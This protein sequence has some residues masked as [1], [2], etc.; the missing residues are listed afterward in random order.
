MDPNSQS[1]ICVLSVESFTALNKIYNIDSSSNTLEVG[2]YSSGGVLTKTVITV[3]SGAYDIYT[4]VDALNESFND[5]F[6]V[7]FNSITGYVTIEPQLTTTN[8]AFFLI[9][10]NYTGLIKKLGFDLKLISTLSDGI[11]T[12]FEDVNTSGSTVFSITGSNLPDLFYPQMLYVSIDQIRTPNRVTLPYKEYGV[13]L[14]EFPITVG[15]GEVIHSSPNN[16]FEYHIPRLNLTNLTVRIMDQDGVPIG[17]NG[18]NWIL[19]LR[20]T[21]GTQSNED[22]T[23]GRISR[24][25][26]KR[27]IDDP[28]Q[29]NYERVV[30]RGRY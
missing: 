6:L 29:N 13:I 12:G 9:S 4:L 20:M 28:L 30:R 1:T 17:W 25:V 23:L 3:N 2:L 26:L 19:V 14:Q 24:P 18:G 27:T 5:N 15:F 22:P 21:Y 7:T 16:T 8:Y 10:T 11:N